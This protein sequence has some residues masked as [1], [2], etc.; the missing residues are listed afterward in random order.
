[1]GDPEVIRGILRTRSITA[2][3]LAWHINLLRD[4]HE[5]HE[6]RDQVTAEMDQHVSGIK[7]SLTGRDTISAEIVYRLVL[8]NLANMHNVGGRPLDDN[9][10]LEVLLSILEKWQARLA[11]AVAKT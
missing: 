7:K 11:P 9:A 5:K 10:R 4:A 2:S 8:D 1:V 3:E 6:S